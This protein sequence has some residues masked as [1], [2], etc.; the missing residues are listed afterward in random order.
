MT[1]LVVFYVAATVSLIALLAIL[2]SLI[3]IVV[4][5]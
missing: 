4:I 3:A 5:R 1:R 2:G